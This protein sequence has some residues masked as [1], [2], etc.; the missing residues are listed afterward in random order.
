MSRRDD[1]G[2][3]WDIVIGAVVGGI[4]GGVST[5]IN[6]NITGKGFSWDSVITGVAIGAGSGVI[7]ASITAKGMASVGCFI[8]TTAISLATKASFGE[9]L[10]AGGAAAMAALVSVPVTN[11]ISTPN[12]SFI[13]AVA[14]GIAS[15]TASTIAEGLSTAGRGIRQGLKNT[16]S[17]PPNPCAV[18]KPSYL[19]I[20]SNKTYSRT[21]LGPINKSPMLK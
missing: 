8:A 5:A 4:I 20:S 10:L 18:I 15:G 1:G 13:D 19:S 3:C 9:A 6:D 21:A 14:K 2:Q 17:H 11:M 7:C 16:N 12:S